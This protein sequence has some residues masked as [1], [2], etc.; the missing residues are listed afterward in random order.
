M[1]PSI[2]GSYFFFTKSKES[3]LRKPYLYI[4]AIL[5]INLIT[6]LKFSRSLIILFLTLNVGSFVYEY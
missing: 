5:L 1:S 3:L 6:N 4:K 2:L